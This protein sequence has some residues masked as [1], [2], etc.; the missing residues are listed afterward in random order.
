MQWVRHDPLNRRAELEEII[1][2]CIRLQL[3]DPS[4][5]KVVLLNCDE[6]ALPADMQRCREYLANAS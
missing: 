4:F 6:F 5:L 2:M 3:L 1:T